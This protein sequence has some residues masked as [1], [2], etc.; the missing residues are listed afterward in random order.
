LSSQLLNLSIKLDRVLD[1]DED[2][3]AK[4]K[5]AIRRAKK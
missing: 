5:P 4:A 2:E 3:P 1:R